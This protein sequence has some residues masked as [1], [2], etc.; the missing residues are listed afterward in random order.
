[1]TGTDV[2][3]DASTIG[4]ERRELW[5]RRFRTLPDRVQA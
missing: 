3:L 5:L 2:V 4:D 1:M